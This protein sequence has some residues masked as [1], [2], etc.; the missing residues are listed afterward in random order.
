VL[1][2][3]RVLSKSQDIL[4]AKN[5]PEALQELTQA[6]G[7][8]QKTRILKELGSKEN[9]DDISRLPRSDKELLD[10]F[11][12]SKHTETSKE[13]LDAIDSGELKMQYKG[14]GEMFQETEDLAIVGYS[15]GL[16]TITVNYERNIDDIL[17]TIVHEGQHELDILAKK[18]DLNNLSQ[19]KIAKAEFRAH[20]AQ[21]EFAKLNNLKNASSFRYSQ[22]DDTGLIQDIYIRYMDEIGDLSEESLSRAVREGNRK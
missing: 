22:M 10:A 15:E 6:E 4:N 3:Q 13:V 21:G 17:T 7:K 11:R 12:N 2:Y 16:K 19:Y 8:A 5:S 14:A 20:K 1:E 18:F 9:V